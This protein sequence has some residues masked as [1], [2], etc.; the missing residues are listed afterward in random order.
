[1]ARQAKNADRFYTGRHA[2]DRQDGQEERH[3]RPYAVALASRRVM[4]SI[5]A[6]QFDQNQFRMVCMRFG[7]RQARLQRRSFAKLP[8][9]ASRMGKRY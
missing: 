2:Q 7:Q 9:V 4:G 1:M 5:I 6:L 8:A 3:R